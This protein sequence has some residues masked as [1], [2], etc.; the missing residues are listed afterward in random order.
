MKKFLPPRAGLL[1]L[2]LVGWLA[3]HTA[4]EPGVTVAGYCQAFARTFCA[5]QALAYQEQSVRIAPH[6]EFLRALS[7]LFHPRDS[8]FTAGVSVRVPRPD[9][10]RA[11]AAIFGQSLVDPH[12]VVRRAHPMGAP[13]DSPDYLRD[14]RDHR[15]GGLWGLQ[16]PGAVLIRTVPDTLCWYSLSCNIILLLG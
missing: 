16:V 1:V 15:P 11:G 12:L 10:G 8:T 5:Q 9:P 4:A 13:S 14:G 2:V 7:N 6:S 3:G